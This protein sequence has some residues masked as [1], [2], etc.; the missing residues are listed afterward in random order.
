MRRDRRKPPRNPL[1]R[2]RRVRQTKDDIDEDDYDDT[3]FGAPGI[4][5]TGEYHGLPR[6]LRDDRRRSRPL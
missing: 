1:T 2:K 6:L 5:E 4:K 3:L